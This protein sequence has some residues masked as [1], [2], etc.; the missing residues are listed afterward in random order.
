M[1]KQKHWSSSS[2]SDN[3]AVL[4]KYRMNEWIKKWM[5]E[6]GN[7]WMKCWVVLTLQDPQDTVFTSVFVC[8]FTSLQ[9]C[10]LCL[11]SCLCS[12]SSFMACHGTWNITI[13]SGVWFLCSLNNIHSQIWDSQTLVQMS[14]MPGTQTTPQSIGLIKTLSFAPSILFSA[15]SDPLV[16]TVDLGLCFSS[17]PA[18]SLE[19]WCQH[20]LDRKLGQ[21]ASV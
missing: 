14:N 4:L 12:Q 16:S 9:K 18:L 15:N 10:V 21:T 1:F 13:N 8:S 6:G 2:A 11:S 19:N 3:L 7:E 20:R 5:M 17:V